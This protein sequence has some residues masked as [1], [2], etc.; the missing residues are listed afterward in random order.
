M[1]VSAVTGGYEVVI[2]KSGKGEIFDPDKK[3]MNYFLF[4]EKIDHNM[5]VNLI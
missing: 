1:V 5:Y 4:I 3:N 2:N